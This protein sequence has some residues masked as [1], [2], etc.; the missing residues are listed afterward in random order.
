MKLKIFF[1]S[2]TRENY[3]KPL[4]VL[5]GTLKR[6][7]TILSTVL[8]ILVTLEAMDIQKLLY[9]NEIRQYFQN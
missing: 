5:V 2:R 3:L 9:G 7:S 6:E 8:L 1:I 4:T